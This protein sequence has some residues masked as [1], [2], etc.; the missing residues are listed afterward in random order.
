M[1]DDGG[2]AVAAVGYAGEGT[3]I[4]NVMAP[5]ELVEL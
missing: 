5:L 3:V 4:G 2:E 1:Q